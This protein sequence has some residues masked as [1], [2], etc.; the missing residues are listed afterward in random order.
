MRL[1]TTA[2]PTGRRLAP[3]ALL[4]AL[5]IAGCS[6]AQHS[7]R[8]AGSAAD[9]RAAVPAPA[10]GSA[11]AEA[12][13][14]SAKG[15]PVAVNQVPLQQRDIV[16]TA[17]LNVTVADADRAATKA[18]ATVNQLGGRADGD[19][20]GSDSGD[21][22]A[23]LVLRVPSDRLDSLITAV[24]ALGHEN[25]RADHGTDVTASNADVNARVQALTISV[26]RLQDYL[27]HSASITDLLALETQLGQRQAELE[28]TQ[29]QQ[30]ALADQ[31]TLAT[32]TVQLSTSA[33]VA[34]AAAGPSGFG[35][36]LVSALHA[37]LLS[38]RWLAAMLGYLM[39]FV[40]LAALVGYPI[41]RYRR[42]TSAGA[43]PLAVE[44]A[45]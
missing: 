15:A 44:P 29:A 10:L 17:T 32:L 6:G 23:E 26:G 25:S 7:S 39:P 19:D 20:R 2:A 34:H 18:V 1:P 13:V 16:R 9:Q 4:A 40:V 5:A 3:L 28:S 38:L 35:S 33:P 27:K 21:R 31:I 43:Q 8:S 24:A 30:R 14:P 22:H 36:A 11:G 45:E 42:R 37:M 41:L 12:V